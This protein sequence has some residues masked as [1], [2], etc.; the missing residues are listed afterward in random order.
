MIKAIELAETLLSG[1]TKEAWQIIKA[2]ENNGNLNIRQSLITPAMRHIGDLWEANEISVAD[3]HLATAVCD[4]LIA[5]MASTEKMTDAANKRAMF[6]CVQGEK[7]FLGLKMAAQL[8][9]ENGWEIKY[10]GADLPLEYALK[11]ASDWNPDA[12]CLSVSIVYHLPILAEYVAQLSALP[13][14][15]QILIGSRLAGKYNL[16]SDPENQ[17]WV[18]PDFDE[19]DRWLKSDSLGEKVNATY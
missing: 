18:I 13:L 6:L 19:M 7:H 17:V 9:E 3:E 16:H 1:K 5:R 10:F 8:F 2:E 14:K 11:I 15:P 4:F 12:I